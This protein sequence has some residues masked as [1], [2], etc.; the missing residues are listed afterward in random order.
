MQRA[1]LAY[2]TNPPRLPTGSP[3]NKPMAL[4]DR[5]T[6]APR[7]LSFKLRLYA[8]SHAYVTRAVETAWINR[9]HIF[10]K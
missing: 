3:I 8:G 2:T 4:I 10:V 5:Y 7:Q 9:V 6:T 1:S